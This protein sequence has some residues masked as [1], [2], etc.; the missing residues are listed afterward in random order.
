VNTSAIDQLPRVEA[1]L[2]YIEPMSHK[3]RSLEYEPPQGVARTTVVYRDHEV[4]IRDVRPVASAL[5]LER[6]GFQLIT[7]PCSVEDFYDEEAVRTRYYGETVSLLEKLTGAARVVV[8]DH[9]IRRRIP[10]ATDRT[11]GIPRQ[12]VASVHNDYTV[13]SGPQRVRD[14]LGEDA[15]A[16]LRRRF[17][18]INVWRPI[19]GPIQDAPLAVADAQSVHGDDLV[20]TDL[21]YPDRTGEIYYVKFNPAHRWFYASAMRQDE[22]MLIKCYDS[23]DDGR[24]RFVPHSAFVDPTTPA[25]ALPRESIELRTLVFYNS[26]CNVRAIPAVS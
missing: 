5:S 9:T 20:A 16:L 15:S 26:E 22:V 10:G 19:R 17:S 4:T 24:A 12:P 11:T 2:R 21:V 23:A 14:L 7:A 8:F 3:P 18:V 1:A 25:G 6:E 13:K